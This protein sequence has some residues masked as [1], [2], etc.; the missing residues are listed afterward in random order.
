[1]GADPNVPLDAFIEYAASSNW[2]AVHLMQLIGVMLI[3]ASLVLL[4]RK[5]ADGPAAEWAVLGTAGT[6]VSLAIASAL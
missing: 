5:M 1:M 2:V 6:V 3:A 4:S